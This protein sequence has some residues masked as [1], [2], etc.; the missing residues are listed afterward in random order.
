MAP[1]VFAMNDAG[2]VDVKV[3]PIPRTCR[4]RLKKPPTVVRRA[5][6]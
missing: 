6:S 5:R 3:D 4:D 2:T 1:D